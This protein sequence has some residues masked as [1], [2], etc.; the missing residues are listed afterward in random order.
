MLTI[1]HNTLL[2]KWPMNPLLPQGWIE[3]LMKREELWSLI[4]PL[5]I[6]YLYIA[7]TVALTLLALNR[8]TSLWKP[9][10]YSVVSWNIITS[11]YIGSIIQI[12]NNDHIIPMIV[13]PHIIARVIPISYFIMWLGWYDRNYTNMLADVEVRI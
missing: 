6:A 1:I 8:A 4:F 5:P 2:V 10:Q 9:M 7:Q 13:V 11:R 3:T 12:W